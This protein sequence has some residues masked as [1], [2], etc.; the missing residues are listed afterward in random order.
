MFLLYYNADGLM[1]FYDIRVLVVVYFLAMTGLVVTTENKILSLGF[2]ILGLV[3]GKVGFDTLHQIHF[4]VPKYTPLDGG[5]PFYALFSGFV[6]I[7]A[8]MQYAKQQ[9]VQP[10]NR[11]SVSWI[12]MLQRFKYLFNLSNKLSIVRGSLIGSVA[13][14]I[15]GASY[16]ISSNLADRIEARIKNEPESRLLAAESANNSAAIT[17]LLPLIFF[18]VPIIPSEAIILGVAETKGFGYT[19]SLDF[20]KNHIPLLAFSL[21]IANMLTWL[22]AG[23]FYYFA[24]RIYDF[25]RS[26]IYSGMII[27]VSTMVLYVGYSENQLFLASMTYAVAV[28]VGLAVRY[29]D[30][31]FVLIFA[32]FL[33]NSM[34]DNLYRF[35]LIYF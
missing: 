9:Q 3:L 31:K 6:I 16:V 35:W 15:P 24:I 12:P 28:L 19:V 20:I 4:M 1:W 21:L 5:L 18:A 10:F 22:M 11:A 13:G 33:S 2:L 8:L 30:S 27:A 29:Q 17:V 14:L 34:L 7:P 25:L 26:W 23:V 32:F